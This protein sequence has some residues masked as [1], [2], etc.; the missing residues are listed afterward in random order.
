M[1]NAY[2]VRKIAGGN[3]LIEE[4]QGAMKDDYKSSLRQVVITGAL[5]DYI[6]F[7]SASEAEL[8]TLGDLFNTA[9]NEYNEQF[10]DSRALRKVLFGRYGIAKA[11]LKGVDH[12]RL[13]LPI[14]VCYRRPQ[15]T[16]QLTMPVISSGRHR[17]LALQALLIAAGCDDD[18]I[19]STQVRVSTIVV[20]NDEQFSQLMENNNTS[21]NQST[22]ELK[23]H[24][25]SGKGINTA[26]LET[27]LEFTYRA[28]DATTQ[29]DFFAQAVS[30]ATRGGSDAGFAFNVAKRAWGLVKATN[31]DNKVWVKELY[32]NSENVASLA[33]AV[34]KAIP[35][36]QK[37]ANDDPLVTSLVP[38][39]AATLAQLIAAELHVTAPEVA[40]V[41]EVAAERLAKQ[42]A[43][44]QELEALLRR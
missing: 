26:D 9:K 31:K 17:L 3:A 14:Q 35:S 28:N 41:K 11:T 10:I 1:A 8:M 37:A 29:A 16:T 20:Q 15:Y 4:L 6:Q 36:A 43:A 34:A 32:S 13:G 24:S 21:R 33:E 39:V 12:C 27:L 42:Q 30:L 25:L 7:P 23:V 18:Q 38:P 44:V 19:K 5:P 22:H 2:D 40:S